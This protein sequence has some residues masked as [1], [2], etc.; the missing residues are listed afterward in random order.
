MQ[1]KQ[2]HI[3][4]LNVPYPANYGG[5]I[6][7]FYKIKELYELGVKI[8]LHCYKYGRS[9]SKELEQLCT[10]VHYYPRKKR[11]A[12][13]FS[14]TP[15]IVKSRKT[16][17]LLENLIGID[18]PILFEGLHTCYY[19][20]HPKLIDRG[21]FVRAHNIESDY[22]KALYQAER[23]LI[24]KLYLFSEYFKIKF[25]EKEV[26]KA[27][28]IFAISQKDHEYFNQKNKSHYIKPFHPDKEIQ[29]KCGIGEYAIYHG[30]LS[31]AE[32]ENAA[33][34]LIQK[35][36]SKIDF[37][38]VITGFKPSKYLRKEV[39]KHKYIRIVESPEESLL[40]SSIENAQIQVLPTNQDTGIKL[41]LLKS[42]Y[43]GRHCILSKKMAN[44]TGIENTCHIANSASEWI[45]KIRELEEREFSE[46]DLKIRKE[47][48]K[49]F[50][51]KT[52]AEKIIS[53]MFPVE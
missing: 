11:T 7:I 5:A 38:L 43:R 22:Y 28:G 52:E 29:I 19:L 33:L 45:K 13:L 23:K 1:D 39:R 2:L 24:D 32:N 8:H 46:E 50:N 3:I 53:L 14:K 21:R 15:F 47:V 18:A 37:P 25:Y 12:N 49:N 48:L 42:L 34:F 20:N 31:V 41:K 10:S 27:T 16:K 40:N 36:F 9:E 4:A 35:V 6:D 17:A 26:N 44:I 51:S 30:N